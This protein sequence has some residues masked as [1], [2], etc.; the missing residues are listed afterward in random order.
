MEALLRKILTS[1]QIKLLSGEK[2]QIRW[3]NDEI[4]K[5]ITL[6]YL[7]RRGFLH[8][9]NEMNIPQPGDYNF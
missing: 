7:S 9:K 2:K 6:R 4:A 1:N 5:A 3:T 8:V